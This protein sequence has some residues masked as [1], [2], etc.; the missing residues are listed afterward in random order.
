MKLTGPEA[1]A[2]MLFTMAPRGRNVEKSCPMPPPACMV[3]A[4]SFTLSKMPLRSSGMRPSTK[5]LNSVTVRPVPAPAR[6]RPAGR[7]PKSA[8][9]SWNV[10]AHFSCTRFP[11]FSTLAAARATRQKVS[12]RLASAAISAEPEKRYLRA[13]ISREIGARN[14]ADVSVS[15]GIGPS[16]G[17]NL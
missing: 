9:A 6:M 16:S 15:G 14:G 4:A 12:S 3:R 17:F 11:P 10:R 5:Q 7:K 2:P 13:Q 8:N 1:S